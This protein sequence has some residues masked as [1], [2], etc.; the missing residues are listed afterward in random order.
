MGCRESGKALLISNVKLKRGK[1]LN[2]RVMAT[3]KEKGG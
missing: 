3:G 1:D 2:I